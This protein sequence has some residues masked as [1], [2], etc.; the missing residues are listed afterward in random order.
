[1]DALKQRSQK[2]IEKPVVIATQQPPKPGHNAFIFKGVEGFSALGKHLPKTW[3]DA[4]ELPKIPIY[5]VSP[6]T[7][8]KIVLIGQ[9]MIENLVGSRASNDL[10][11]TMLY[12]AVSL[13]DPGDTTKAFLNA[14]DTAIWKRADLAE[15]NANDTKAA[16]RKRF[17]EIRNKN[18][19]G[20]T[21][22]PAEPET[23]NAVVGDEDSID[24]R[25]SAYCYIA[26]YLMRLHVC[27]PDSFIKSIK[28]MQERFKGWYAA[29]HKVIDSFQLEKSMANSIKQAFVRR[30]GVI[31]T[32]VMWV[33]YNENET[34][35]GKK[36][37]ELMEYLS[38]QV[39]QYIGMHALTLTV[40]LQQVTKCDM[41]FLLGELKCPMTRE[42]VQAIDHLLQNH[43]LVKEKP[44]SKTYFR[45]ARVWDSD[46]FLEI[47]SKNVPN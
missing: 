18:R 45:Y 33:A 23:V 34:E 36:N 42:A 19:T 28:R 7:S 37:K 20:S 32:W 40:A 47:Q 12:L 38:G 25:A 9:K 14:P 8:S 35:M 4:S 6:M 17:D 39:F 3:N 29:G 11:D 44:G 26:A 5:T 13:R 43:E 41:G 30:S 16:L 46:Y 2:A 15:P 10:V 22:T 24:D 31:S 21:S 1:M 27:Q